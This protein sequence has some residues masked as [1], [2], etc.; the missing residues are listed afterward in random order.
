MLAYK[1]F[2]KGLICRD[3]QFNPGLNVTEKANCA[4]NGFHCAEN[5]LDCFNYY[6][7]IKNSEYYIVDAGGDIDE[8]E[9]DSK[10]SCTHLTILKRLTLKDLLLHSLAYINDHPFRANSSQVEREIGKSRNGY[11]IVRG[12]DP[13]ASG[14]KGDYLCLAKEEPN[15][16]KIIQIAL[17]KVD[18]KRIMPNRLYNVNLEESEK[19]EY[20]KKRV[21]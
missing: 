21:A 2:D 18:G 7:N 10:I 13:V 9:R 16:K 12:K 11:V 4:K 6:P 1:G 14:E 8:D 5:P 15:S 3:Y 20:D 19:T 17:V